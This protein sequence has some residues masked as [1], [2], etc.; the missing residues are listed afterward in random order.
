MQSSLILCSTP[1]L[2]RSLRQAH[3]RRQQ[4]QGRTQ[5][6]TLPAMTLSQWLGELIGDALLRGEIVAEAVPTMVPG[7]LQER[8]LWERAVESSLSG[9]AAEALFDK[10]GMAATAM[11]ANRLLQAWRIVLPAGEQTEETQQFLRWRAAFRKACAQSGWLESTR[12]LEWQ[13]DQLEAGKGH[14]PQT[15]RLAGFDRVSPQEQRLLGVL[16]TRGV[17]VSF[18][19]EA[20][21]E[22]VE[23]Q[24]VRLPD[25]EAECRA[26]AAWAAS[27]LA[28]RPDARLAVVAPDLAAVRSRLAA[29]LDDVL[30]PD[31]LCAAASESPRRY[32]FSLGQPLSSVPVVGAALSLLRMMSGRRQVEQRVMSGLLLQP[33]WSNGGREADGR[34]LL[35]A[36][37]R[38]KLPAFFSVDRFVRFVRHQTEQGA[39][40]QGLVEALENLS[41]L[42]QR[43]AA[44]QLPSAW[45]LLFRQLLG[46]AAWPGD[47]SLSSH[48]FQAREAFYEALEGLRELDSLLGKIA[49]GEAV[50]YLTQACREQIFQPRTQ[51]DPNITIMGMLE[52]LGEPVDAMW[53][54]GMNDHVWP[55]PP[56]PN[57][58]LPVAAQRSAR[59]PN[60]DNGVQNEFAQAIHT[61]LMRS[62]HKLVFSY[63]EAEGDRKLRPSPLIAELPVLDQKV[64]TAKTLA[65]VLADMPG[66]RELEADHLAPE[67]MEGERVRGG[68][69]L[70]K[71]QAICPAWAYYQFRLGATRLA[72]PVEGLD[73][74]GRGTLLHAALECFWAGRDSAWLAMLDDAALDDAVR[75]AVAQAIVQFNA[76]RDEALPEG[77]LSLEAERLHKVVLGWVCFEKARETPFSVAACEQEQTLEIEGITV[78]L[79]MDRIDRLEDGGV[80]VVDYKTGAALDVKNWATD[81]MTEPQLPIYASLALSG[82]QVVA[83]AFA[84]VRVDDP[85]YV[86]VAASESVLP[87]VPGLDDAR[88]RKDFPDTRFPDWNT[89]LEHWRQRVAA[90]AREVRSGEAAVR[91]ANEADLAYC[92]V[93]PLL[94]LPERRLLLESQ[95][96]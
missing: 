13:I 76:E 43:Q 41:T 15:I 79:V 95:Q 89:L 86:G 12:Y 83:V 93:L 68:A 74:A 73:A 78:K 69:R 24:Q 87:G 8:I 33:Y 2:A 20:A 62:G 7:N 81:R 49:M 46:A 44:R 71:A 42:M 64:S 29:L 40:T 53:V 16:Q 91:F 27:I 55:P 80:V 57:P 54:M 60:A 56:R 11:E 32:D 92:E 45:V 48:E 18:W 66:Q 25:Q 94:R 30:Q 36:A 51:G 61:R 26:V 35:D 21:V 85:R 58:L 47:R 10:A 23:V 82:E 70:L 50:R 31:T 14:L 88:V 72:E 75:T 17:A 6:E 77:F 19:Q 39:R 65:E 59:A 37:M 3:A 28:E 22:A 67:V 5:W 90:I 96:T 84:R 63:A 4:S 1:R 9:H 38:Q 34:A 52:S